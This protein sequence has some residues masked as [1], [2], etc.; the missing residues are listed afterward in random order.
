[1]L[2]DYDFK[3]Q[4]KPT[5]TFGHA[6]GLSRLISKRRTNKED[7]DIVIASIS[8]DHEIYQIFR[9]S[10][11]QLPVSVE[12][13]AAKT[14]TDPLLQNVIQYLQ[15][16]WPSTVTGEAKQLCSRKDALTMVGDCLMFGNRVVIPEELRERVLT[17]LHT[18][19]PGISRMKTLAR[20]YVYWPF[21]DSQIEDLVR[22]CNQCAA[23]AKAPVKSQLFSWPQPEK[24]WERVHLDFAG[25]INRSYFL[26]IVNAYSKWSKGF[27]MQRTS[28]IATLSIISR[29]FSQFGNPE[30][31]VTDN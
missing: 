28:N 23:V 15:N 29:L 20:S 6:D 5:S 4:Y 21:I 10:V 24:C 8:F 22:K 14:A 1:M 30:L 19:H 25:P 2:L 18:G 9:E 27:G 17:Q 3:L 31:I 13:I 26:V 11:R 12:I 16:G 7:E